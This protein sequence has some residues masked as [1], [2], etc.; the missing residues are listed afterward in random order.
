VGKRTA[1][2][3]ALLLMGPSRAKIIAFFSI[4]MERNDV[5][6]QTAGMDFNYLTASYS[7]PS[8]VLKSV[9]SFAAIVV[10]PRSFESSSV[11]PHRVFCDFNFRLFI[12]SPSFNP[13][14]LHQLYLQINLTNRYT[15]KKNRA[16]KDQL[17]LVK[18]AGIRNSG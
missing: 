15:M 3:E 17:I 14:F 12:V 9:I 18:V 7:T 6:L 2:K 10:V 8:P 4:E 1:A 11:R 13:S 5:F 16:L